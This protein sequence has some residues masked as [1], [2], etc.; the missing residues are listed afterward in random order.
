MA[1]PESTARGR[2]KFDNSRNIYMGVPRE[3]VLSL[4]GQTTT[5]GTITLTTPTRVVVVKSKPGESPAELS[6]RIYARLFPWLRE[7][8][9]DEDV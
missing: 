1:H 5:P 7:D 3:T 4:S 8:G 9:D 6:R 2:V